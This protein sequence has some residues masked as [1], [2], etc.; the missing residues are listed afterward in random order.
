M[1]LDAFYL[2]ESLTSALIQPCNA[3]DC[4]SCGPTGTK[5]M[6]NSQILVSYVDIRSCTVLHSLAV[7]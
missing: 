3:L 7:S 4:S 6:E 1:A 2:I 5:T